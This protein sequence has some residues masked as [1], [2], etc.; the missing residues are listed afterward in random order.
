[1]LAS[2]LLSEAS[3]SSIVS[4]LARDLDQMRLADAG[5]QGSAACDSQFLKGAGKASY[6]AIGSFDRRL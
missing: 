3:I 4:P 5:D 6:A 1:V 2:A